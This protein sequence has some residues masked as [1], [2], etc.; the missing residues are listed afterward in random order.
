L[1]CRPLG[2]RVKEE[3]IVDAI[4]GCRNWRKR[5][6]EARLDVLQV[7]SNG[8]FGLGVGMTQVNTGA[9]DKTAFGR[10]RHGRVERRY[11]FRLERARR[12]VGR[13][14]RRCG[15]GGIVFFG[16]KG[17]IVNVDVDVVV[18]VEVDGAL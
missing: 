4:V 9:V 13:R 18:I 5:G 15:G 3:S 12:R 16:G 8:E 17:S 2:G 1:R 11:V 6:R 7:L 14:R 10:A